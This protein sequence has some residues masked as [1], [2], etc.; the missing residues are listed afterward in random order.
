[1]R[2][3]LVACALLGLLACGGA[4][5]TVPEAVV[6]TID[7]LR[8]EARARPN[9]PGA[10]RALAE[11]ELLG[12]G[13]DAAAARAAIDHAAELAP[14]DPIVTFLSATEHEQHGRPG[15]ALAAYLAAA[16][17]ARASD[18]PLAPAVAE[19]AIWALGGLSEEV[20]DF[21]DRVRPVLE[22]VL[23]DPGRLGLPARAGASGWLVGHARGRGD[24][25]RAARIAG[26]LG[27]VR[28]ARLAGPFGPY[29]MLGFDETLPAE[30]RGPL[31]ERYDL[32]PTRGP[33]PTRTVE[34]QGCVLR[35]DG[36]ALSAA[37]S[38][39][40]EA[41]VQIDEPGEHLLALDTPNPVQ[42]RVD[43]ELVATVDRRTRLGPRYGFLPLDLA[44]GEH[45]IEV[46]ISS[47][48]P[49]PILYLVLDRPS[50][51]YR[52]ERGVE[53]PAPDGPAALVLSALVARS[54][55]DDLGMRERLLPVEAA[56][57]AGSPAG[58]PSAA[59]LALAATASFGDPFLPSDRKRDRAR[60]ALEAASRRDPAAWWPAVRL[61][62]MEQGGP[63]AVARMREVARR[64]PDLVGVQL[65][66]ADLLSE[67]GFEA[68][69]EVAVARA[70]ELNPRSC[71]A[72]RA[73]YG[74]LRGRLRLDR[75]HALVDDLVGCDARSRAR[76]DMLVRQRR[77]EDAARELAR[78]RPLLD[79][80][81]ARAL[82]LSL[83]VATGDAERESELLAANAARYPLDPD[84]PL[85]RADRW[86]A[87][88]DRAGAVRVLG[89]AIEDAPTYMTSLRRTRRAIAGEDWLDR[90]RVDGD[91][92]IRRFEASGRTYEEH[93]QVLVFDYMVIRIHPD[94]SSTRLVHQIL[95]VQGEESIE[96]LGQL[97]LGGRALR[98]RSIKPD[99][100][101]L[102]P[103][104]IEGIDH[105]EMPSLA[106]GD[107]VEYEY[108]R[109][110]GARNNGGFLSG[111]WWFQSFGQ[112]FD[113]SKL[114]VLAPR[115]LELVVDARGPVPEAVE[116]ADGDLRVLT[117]T[118]EESRPLVEEPGWVPLP[119]LLPVI[120]LG[121]NAGWDDYFDAFRD[122]LADR[123][124][125][126]P[127]I[128]R[129]V[130]R[131]LGRAR[132]ASVADR[133]R[134][135][136]EW[137]LENIESGGDF[138]APAPV[139]V[140]ARTGSR[141][142][143]LRYLLSLAGIPADL[144]VTRRFG[145]REPSDL[146]DTDV[147]DGALVM[148]PRDGADP[149]F[150]WAEDRG[151]PFDFLPP[152][153]RG[154]EA[155]VLRDGN[156]RLRLPDPS[157]DADRHEVDI[158]L[159][160]EADG[161]ARARIA[162]TLHGNAAT[163]WRQQL[164]DIPEAELERRFE[165]GYAARVLPGA[166][167]TSLSVE[168]RRDLDRP[169]VFRYD[170]RVRR[171]GRRVGR[172]LLLPSMFEV[173]PAGTWARLASRTSTMAVWGTRRD[174]R[175]ALRAAAGRAHGPPDV[176]LEGPG[177]ARFERT[178][179][180]DGDT[181]VVERSVAIP[182]MLVRADGYARFA[183]F[184]RQATEAE[185]QEAYVGR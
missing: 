65:D 179:Q 107:Y 86:L 177:G 6:P 104:R 94:G 48:H 19:V 14:H 138:D 9:D 38:W 125:F 134:I 129:L 110:E 84:A 21:D 10:W 46:K 57:E 174:V 124:P 59:A 155:V 137:V 143:V 141:T 151:A 163:F 63:E 36:G 39:V 162:E 161:S 5:P 98:L 113:I 176:R 157:A 126:D 69:S 119:E 74:V 159:E 50:G 62:W 1:M 168:G 144:V 153:Y 29:P 145:A 51:S 8:A 11:W 166:E 102:E 43:G 99:G 109:E 35:F 12:E 135:L 120:S 140:H 41:T 52:P 97:R 33:H 152:V 93:G 71:E 81:D 28:Q 173:D 133:A 123:D 132:D 61:A 114:V 136:R 150:L 40:A 171:I 89:E 73:W 56:L 131:I 15:P 167:L 68:D 180:Q 128:A 90:W 92:V 66:L 170:L 80:D 37:G 160:V 154:Q 83:A 72:L 158:A 106:V 183:S 156:P 117:W 47:R 13:G 164:E 100:R 45:E 20:P 105:I 75:A 142:R 44:R 2:A 139:A 184:C 27:C 64:F 70:R 58:E 95:R 185:H 103:D 79:A 67:H 23:G 17:Q 16:D 175:L 169:L 165:A 76:Y 7:R 42:V 181:L 172:R 108:V 34:A 116:S 147:W 25:A 101:V 149:L 91:E 55:F 122:S 54:R 22:R 77:W 3:A 49:R 96:R 78:L 26:E 18:D 31:A 182:R 82:E 112:P 111:G 85:D 121:V 30:G 24:P 53:P 146:V 127:A 88:G 148:V 130:R 4:A 178:S 60:R 87:G 115:E 32:G 118:V